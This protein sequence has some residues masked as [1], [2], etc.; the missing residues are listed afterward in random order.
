VRDLQD[1]VARGAAMLDE[2][3][4]GWFT[5]VPPARLD[6]ASCSRCVLGH[7]YEDYGRGMFELWPDDYDSDVA[8]AHGFTVR[9][10]LAS[11]ALSWPV[12]TDA[13]REEIA[14]R[15]LAAMTPQPTRETV[16]A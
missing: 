4:P 5:R 13:W 6:L 2:R 11:Q 7:L 15:R 1:K 12:L 10:D 14:K 8:A 9:G 16:T 3:V